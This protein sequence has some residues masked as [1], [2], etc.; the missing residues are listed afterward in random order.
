MSTFNPCFIVPVYNH[1]HTLNKT[2]DNLT[3]FEFPIILV[4]DG[5]SAS[6]KLVIK[7]IAEENKKVRVVEHANNRGK[8]A[9]VKSGLST[10]FHHGFSHALQIDADGQHNIADIPIFLEAAKREPE[11]LISGTPLYDDSV[12]KSRLYGRY[13]THIWVWI[14]TLSFQIKD[15]MCGFRVYPLAA[16]EVLCSEERMG[17]RMD[18]DTEFIVRWCWRCLPIQQLPTRVIYPEN[19][20]S[21]FLVWRDNKLI[22]WMHTRLFFGMLYRLPRLLVRKIMR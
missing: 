18:F 5:C 21:H 7:N 22:T 13:V 20:I 1:E 10:A 12:P 19:G 15:S 17:N 6:C 3:G 14:N 9:A 2:I 11:S 8:G 16:S 4:D